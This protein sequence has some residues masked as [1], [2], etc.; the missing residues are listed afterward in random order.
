LGFLIRFQGT[1][2]LDADAVES[3]IE[4]FRPF[5]AQA[6]SVQKDEDGVF[7]PTGFS[8]IWFFDRLPPHRRLS[9]G[10]PEA[11]GFL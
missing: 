2:R 9:T 5:R 1:F 10:E 6:I 11:V 8:P 3:E 4:R 7:D